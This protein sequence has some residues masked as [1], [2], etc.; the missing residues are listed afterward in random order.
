MRQL[1]VAA[2]GSGD[3]TGVQAAIDAVR[4][5][6]Q[7]DTRIFI[8]NGVYHEKIVIPDNKTR[9]WLVGESREGTVLTNGEY[10]KITGPDGN[11]IG[12]FLTPVLTMAGDDCRLE[13]LTVQNTAGY[14]PEIGQALALYSA[15]DRLIV[16]NVRLLGNQDTLY[17]CK[18]RQYF[19]RCYIEGHVD[20]IFGG[21]TAVFEECEIHSLREGFITAASTESYQPY[22][23][24]F[25]KCRLTGSTAAGSVFLGRPW[26]PFAH[27]VFIHTWMGP[28]I[29]VEGWDNWRE[30][31]NELTARYSEYGS[32]GPGAGQTGRAGWAR[33]LTPEEAGQMTAKYVLA[34]ADEW[35]PEG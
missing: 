25:L 21:A 10:A 19:H 14:G 29:H 33:L 26:R 32:T 3:F 6:W 28:H 15:G 16:R 30:P 2:D 1:T 24:V 35:N 31:N 9:I 17:T 8:K 13:N 23:Y 5:H 20:F 27:T 4:V 11:E 34:G 18:G 22:G 12:T 7:D